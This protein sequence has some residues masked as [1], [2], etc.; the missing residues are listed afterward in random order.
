[1]RRLIQS[2]GH[3]AGP[4]QAGML[5]IKFTVIPRGMDL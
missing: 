4:L 5:D 3:T 1:V 2:L